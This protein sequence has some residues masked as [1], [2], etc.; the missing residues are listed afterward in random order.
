MEIS[1]PAMAHFAHLHHNSTL[2]IKTDKDIHC[3]IMF[4]IAITSQTIN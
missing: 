1:S 3:R 4:S 2:K